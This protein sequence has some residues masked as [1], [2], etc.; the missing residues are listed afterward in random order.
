MGQKQP[1][2][3][4]TPHRYRRS[5]IHFWILLPVAIIIA[6]LYLSGCSPQK[7]C[8]GTRGMSGYSYIRNLETGRVAVLDK[9][10]NIC[11]YNEAQMSHKE[12]QEYL[13]SKY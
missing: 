9:D 1:L 3:M 11:V 13:S 7:G 12:A 10:G 5:V 8:Y 4:N 2:I 6:M